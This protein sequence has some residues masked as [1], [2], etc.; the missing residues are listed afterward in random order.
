MIDMIDELINELNEIK[1][2]KEGLKELLCDC[3]EDEST[4][5]CDYPT[6][7]ARNIGGTSITVDTS[8][9]T[10]STNPV[11]NKVVTTELNK[12]QEKL[13]SGSNIKTINGT[14]IL[15]SGNITIQSG[16]S[17]GMSLYDQAKAVISRFNHQYTINIDKPA[18][19]EVD[20]ILF[21]GQSNSCGRAQLSDCKNPEDIILSVPI[22]KGFHFNGTTSST[23]IEIVEPISANGSSTYGYVSAFLTAYY[24][25]TKRQVCACFQSVGG[26][27]LSK[28]VPYVLDDNSEPTTTEGAYYKLMKE[29]VNHAKT[30]LA[31]LGYTVGGV[32]LVWC[33][34]ENDAYYYGYT[35]NYATL[36]EQSLTTPELKTTYYKELFRT[37]VDALKED[38]GLST[39]FMMRIGHRKE[40]PT[41]WEMYGPI[42]EAQNQLCKE[43]DDC[44]MVSTIFAGAEKFIEEDGTVRNLMRDY[45]HYTPEGYARAGLEGGTNAGIYINSGKR[46]KPIL[47]EYQTL[48]FDDTTVYERPFDKFIYDPCRVDFNLMKKFASDKVTSISVNFTTTSL[49]VGGT[50]QIVATVYPTTVSNKKVIY[51]VWS[52]DIISV[53]ENGLITALK[54]GSSTITVSSDMDP[55]I[56][57]DI[58]VNV[59]ASVIPVE[60]ITLNQ[61]SGSMLVG[62]TLQLT[63]TIT[64]NNATDKT[65]T[66]TSSDGGCVSVDGNGLCTGLEQGDATITAVPNGNTNLSATCVIDCEHNAG[67]GQE[68]IYMDFSTTPLYDYSSGE[69]TWDEGGYLAHNKGEQYFETLIDNCESDDC[70]EGDDTSFLY[71]LKLAKTFSADQNWS[72][73]TCITIQPYASSGTSKTEAVYKNLAILSTG[74]E[75]TSHANT[76]LSPCVL[77]NGWAGTIRLEQDVS[78][79]LSINNLFLQDGQMHI[80]KFVYDH[81]TYSVEMFVDGAS[82]GKKQWA[83]SPTGNFGYIFGIHKGYSYAANYGMKKGYKLHYIEI[84]ADRFND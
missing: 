23:P 12:K 22:S 61:T 36:K 1:E 30:K 56:Y 16:S 59:S 69:L 33:Q 15:G 8:L 79:A 3:G 67:A 10:S 31:E 80:Y 51:D 41:K 72:V 65:I 47:L 45:T 44:V 82:K 19:K 21:S 29:R 71:G 54:E 70:L 63:A 68:A 18:E 6:T 75:H 73:E 78:T 62:D 42:V 57:V 64:P 13:V 40:N 4:P 60:S 38:I 81:S 46:I 26:A 35:N 7:F 17:G 53:D 5:F 32:Y 48:L 83:N 37:L 11:Q 20:I 14:S 2:T 84:N 24:E 49:G 52:P 55:E 34:G 28:F 9:S 74:H 25:T 66:W 27:N 50:T 39:V 58:E 43:Y 76:C 77:N